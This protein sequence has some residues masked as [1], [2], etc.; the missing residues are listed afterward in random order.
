[1]SYYASKT[2]N[3]GQKNVVALIGKITLETLTLNGFESETVSSGATEN[4]TGILKV[5]R[6]YDR[7]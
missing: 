5:G 7:V 3:M 2:V 6:S 1:M 4:L